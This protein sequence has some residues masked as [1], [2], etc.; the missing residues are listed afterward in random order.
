ML[1]H[2]DQRLGML[3][4]PDDR[5]GIQGSDGVHTYYA[6]ITGPLGYP[7]SSQSLPG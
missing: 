2:R 4:G 1:F 7:L 3:R 6:V 5:P